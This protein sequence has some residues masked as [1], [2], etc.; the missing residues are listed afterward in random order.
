VKLLLCRKYQDVFKLQY[1]RR[2][3]NCGETW[4]KYEDDGL[5]AIYGGKNA[6]PIGFANASLANAIAAQPVK[7][8]LG[9]RF[10]AFIIP[11]KCATMILED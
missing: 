2:E 5:H 1:D 3:C 4:G 9:V 10:E 6:V 8:A 7:S 11:K